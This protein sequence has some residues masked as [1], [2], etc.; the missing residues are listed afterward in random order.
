M[1]TSTP[2]LSIAAF[3]VLIA[4]LA[5]LRIYSQGRITIEVKEIVAA[6]AVVGLGLFVLG[7]VTEVAFGDVKLV[8][9]VKEA[10]DERVESRIPDTASTVVFEEQHTDAK[11]GPGLIPGL[12]DSRVTALSFT[13]GGDYYVPKYVA[14]YLLDLTEAPY[15]R[16]VVFNDD[17]GRLVGIA[18]P[19]TIATAF[20]TDSEE[21][22]PERLTQLIKT[23][24]VKA[25]R[26][27]PGF[28]AVDRAVQDSTTTREA[29]DL[30]VQRHAALLPVIDTSG[31]FKGI[32]HEDKLVLAILHA[33]TG[34]GP[35]N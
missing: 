10:Q 7:E 12:I 25:L 8:R 20:R 1:F 28:I 9:R 15:L 22:T 24:N 34:G 29:L 21:L 2:V 33:L 4:G 31:A 19:R 5:A 35:K 3:V 16:Y 23:D 13:L 14:Q 27:L 6:I 32:V 18:D 26:T 30:M 11:G 17:Q